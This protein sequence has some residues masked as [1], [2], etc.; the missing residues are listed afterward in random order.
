M[1]SAAIG[2]P[3]DRPREELILPLE[4]NGS[5]LLAEDAPFGPEVPDWVYPETLDSDFF[6]PN[7]SGAQR[8]PNGNTLICEGN[9]GHLFEVTPE[10]EMVWE[11]VTA[12][13]QFGAIA[14]GGNPF[15]NSTFRAYRYAPDHPAFTGRDMTPGDP[16]E[17]NPLP[18]D[19][20]LYPAPVDT[21]TQVV[22]EADLALRIGP[23]PVAD[24]L[25]VTAAR[26]LTWI[27][28]DVTGRPVLPPAE[29]RR[30]HTIDVTPLPAGVYHLSLSD[31]SGRAA[32]TRRILIQH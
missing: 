20:Q 22:E 24:V 28:L 12:Y 21:T 8:L 3:L 7:I 14:E 6:S 2:V 19:C 4:P 16:V 9:S 27:L 18:F 1:A 15:G 31:A 23:N 32:G 26:P 5:Y 29:V 11:Y 25:H 10:G 13:N 17:S 30:R